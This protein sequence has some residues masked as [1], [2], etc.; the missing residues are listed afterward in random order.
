MQKTV[1]QRQAQL[2]SYWDNGPGPTAY[3]LP[4]TG[5]H[6]VHIFLFYT[7]SIYLFFFQWER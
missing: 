3:M 6:W 2:S 7:T 1:E 4:P 5:M